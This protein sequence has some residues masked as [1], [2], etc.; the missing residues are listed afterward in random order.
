MGSLI[1]NTAAA[2]QARQAPEKNLL[3]LFFR[4]EQK[5]NILSEENA[6]NSISSWC[7]PVSRC[8]DYAKTQPGVVFMHDHPAAKDAGSE[9]DRNTLRPDVPD[10]DPAANGHG[11][12]L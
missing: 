9:P 10:P 4:T 1:T 11:A 6:A 12:P 7:P 5:K 2:L 8:A 3:V